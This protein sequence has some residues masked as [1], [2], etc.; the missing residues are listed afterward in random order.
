MCQGESL[1]DWRGFGHLF[2]RRSGIIRVGFSSR[3]PWT[4]TVMRQHERPIRRRSEGCQ[5][6]ST[7]RTTR[8]DALPGNNPTRDPN[9]PEIV[10]LKRSS[11]PQTWVKGPKTG[12]APSRHKTCG[13]A[14]VLTL[15]LGVRGI[16]TLL[17]L[18]KPSHSMRVREER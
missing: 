15:T 18:P 8:S 16:Q 4:L 14:S 9:P 7:R 13:L 11:K 10:A 2:S 5:R 3:S 17:P 12:K 1:Q 6:V